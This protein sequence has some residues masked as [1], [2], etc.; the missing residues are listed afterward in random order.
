MLDLVGTRFADHFGALEGFH[1][2]VT[3]EEAEKHVEDFLAH[4]LKDF[5][6]TQDAMVAADPFGHHSLLSFYINVGLID[7]LDLCRRWSGPITR[8]MCR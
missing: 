7:P 8:G 1:F 6:R 5:G 3:A 2:A 4:R